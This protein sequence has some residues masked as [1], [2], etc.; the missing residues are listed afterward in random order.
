[1]AA[2]KD[3]VLLGRLIDPGEA[4]VFGRGAVTFESV[5]FPLAVSIWSVIAGDEDARW[6]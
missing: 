5:L 2:G 1:M 3:G 6:T 4:E